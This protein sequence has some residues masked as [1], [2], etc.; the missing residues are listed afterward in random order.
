MRYT[1]ITMA[2]LPI[3]Y[4]FR[5][6]PYAMRARLALASAGCAVQLREVVLRQKPAHLLEISPKGTVPVLLLADQTVLEQ[7]LDIMQWALA[8]ADPENLVPTGSALVQLEQL[9]TTNDGA[10]KASLDRY[11]YPPRYTQEHGELNPEQ[12]AQQHRSAGAQHLLVLEQRLAQHEFLLGSELSMADLAIAPFVRQFA[13]TDLD[14]FQQQN[15]PHLLRWLQRFL[16]SS[17]FAQVMHKYPPWQP[18][19]EITLFPT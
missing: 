10:F 12:F 16:A 1:R 6:C 4:S 3:L 14:W 17:R 2:S 15:W 7:S 5:R 19:D 9:I 11:K 13:H 8:Q 18:D